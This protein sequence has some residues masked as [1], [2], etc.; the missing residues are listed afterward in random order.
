MHGRQWYKQHESGGHPECSLVR[1]TGSRTM[2]EDSWQC[3]L[4]TPDK[5]LVVA[6]K[7]H[8]ISTHK[9][10]LYADNNLTA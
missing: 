1:R 5:L 2:A 7:T 9:S 8:T 3:T 6:G 10:S 4:F